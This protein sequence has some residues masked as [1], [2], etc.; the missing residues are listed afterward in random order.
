MGKE[1]TYFSDC[2]GDEIFVG[3]TVRIKNSINRDLHGDWS[4]YRV[5][6]RPGGYAFSYLTSEKGQIVPRG[7]LGSYMAT[8]ALDAGN[9]DLKMLLHV[10]DLPAKCSAFERRGRLTEG[11]SGD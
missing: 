9:T 4:D 7:M 3:D 10:Y 6:K 8:T 1:T 2:N 11:G 5:I